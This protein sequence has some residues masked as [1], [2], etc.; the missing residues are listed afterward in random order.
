MNETLLREFDENFLKYAPQLL[1]LGDRPQEVLE[2]LRRAYFPHGPLD[3]NK[4]MEGSNVSRKRAKWS[5]YI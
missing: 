2:S 5:I 3:K 4:M 1:L